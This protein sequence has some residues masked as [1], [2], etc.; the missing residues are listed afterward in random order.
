MHEPAARVIESFFGLKKGLVVAVNADE[1]AVRADALKK[2]H[3]VSPWTNR[4][5]H[6]DPSILKVNEFQHL[7]EHHRQMLHYLDTK[8]AEV[9][10]VTGSIN[11]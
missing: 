8:A 5:I 1:G 9:F 6:I 2:F 11:A 3:R 10:L 4:C 7:R